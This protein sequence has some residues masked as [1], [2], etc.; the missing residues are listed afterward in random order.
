MNSFPR[1]SSFGS[2]SLLLFGLTALP[3]LAAEGPGPD[4]ADSTTG[5][6]FRWLN[7]L[8]VFGGIAYLIA[9]YGRTF[10]RGHAK[11]IAASI[12]EATAVKAEAGRELREVEVKIERLDQDVAELREEARRSWAA[13]A[14]RLR[15]SGL[16]EIEK[17]NQA[18]RAE[19]ASSER[20][21]QHE[22]R[23]IAASIA[24]ERAAVL[25]SSMMNP[26]I[27][28]RMFQSFLGELGKSAQ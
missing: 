19:L 6:I 16:A 4:P 11:E 22:V 13:E 5:L 17:I 15:T 21:A 7:F 10:F 1:F 26:K 8:I 28:A 20:A 3:V 18:A 27:R 14:E 23:E 2:R 25:V 24:V 9:K 12:V